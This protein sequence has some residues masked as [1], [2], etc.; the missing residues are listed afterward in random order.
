MKTFIFLAFIGFS[1]V[2]IFRIM[3]N[4]GRALDNYERRELSNREK[5]DG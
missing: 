2:L 4:I 5:K 3:D 1:V